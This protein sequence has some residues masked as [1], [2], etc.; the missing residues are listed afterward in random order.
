[1]RKKILPLLLLILFPVLLTA[2]SARE[3]D[4]SVQPTVVQFVTD[5]SKVSSVVNKTVETC[6]STEKEGYVLEGWYK[7]EKYQTGRVSF[8][9][10]AETSCKLY[11]KWIDKRVGNDELVFSDLEDGTLTVSACDTTCPTVWIPDEKN[12]KKVSVLASGFLKNKTYLTYLHIGKNVKTIEETFYR[13]LALKEIEVDENNT[14]WS[15]EEGVLYSADKTLLYAYPVAKEG[16]EFSVPSSV[17]ELGV[18]AFSYNLFLKELYLNK[19]L[20]TTASGFK[21]M[22][23]LQKF[24]VE[25]G[26]ETFS[27]KNGVLYSVDGKKLLSFPSCFS[28][29]V[30]S[31]AAGTEEVTENAFYKCNLTTLNI[32]RELSVFNAPASAPSLTAY[33]VEE[34]NAYFVSRD[35]VLFIDEGKILYLAPQ[36]KTGEYI[37]PSGTE[38]VYDFSFY[39]CGLERISFPASVKKIGRFAFSESTSLTEIIFAENSLL[40]YIEGSAFSRCYMLSRLQLT[41]R[42]PPQTDEDIFSSCASD[43]VIV[44]PAYTDGLY[45]AKWPFCAD[46]FSASGPAAALYD[47]TFDAQ[48]GSEVAAVRGAYILQEPETHRDSDSAN[49]YYI[50]LGWY[51]N[52]EGTGRKVEFPYAIEGEL[53]LYAAWDIGYYAPKT[54]TTS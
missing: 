4:E 37:V 30:F 1:M 23:S 19:E 18:H 22:E 53:T 26:S 14:D 46:K 49:E 25:E 33:N 2:C 41:G 44:I 31:V 36:G 8:P 20:V 35:G 16:D 27:S 34:G 42:V 17:V 13:C 32:N 45:Q 29:D 3:Q 6:P 50:F 7:D 47:V 10:R 21:N 24:F 52:P 54:K 9:F 43:L 5:G 12:G 51:D 28:A 15:S 39:K 38:E 48:G 11:A 40:S